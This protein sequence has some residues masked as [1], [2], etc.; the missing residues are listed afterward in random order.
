M[1]ALGI[2]LHQ[3]LTGAHPF[4]EPGRQRFSEPVYERFLSHNAPVKLAPILARGSVHVQEF[5]KLMLDRD[6]LVR[7]TP[8]E[9]LE[10]SWFVLPAGQI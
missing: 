5:V 2:I 1:W 4:A 7:P 10:M 3:I 8:A 6:P 9:A